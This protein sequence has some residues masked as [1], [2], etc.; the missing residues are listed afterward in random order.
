[1]SVVPSREWRWS[2]SNP[3]VISEVTGMSLTKPTH[4]LRAWSLQ[5]VSSQI[6]G[7]SLEVLGPCCAEGPRGCRNP[8]APGG[9]RGPVWHVWALTKGLGALAPAVRA[10]S[11]WESSWIVWIIHF[12]RL[13]GKSFLSS[14]IFLLQAWKGVYVLQQKLTSDIM[15]CLWVA[16]KADYILNFILLAQ[17]E[18]GS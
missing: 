14:S 5:A 10:W 13:M 17:Q 16:H 18:Q 8:G 15:G 7:A 11:R 9:C 12:E 3:S 6:P 1:M 2:Q 4:G